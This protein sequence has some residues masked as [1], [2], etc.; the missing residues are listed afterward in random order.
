MSQILS[1]TWLNHY[2]A[3][4]SVN[5][6]SLNDEFD[7][8]GIDGIFLKYFLRST[9]ER[10]SADLLVPELFNRNNFK[11]ALIGGR[12]ENMLVLR[13]HFLEKFSSQSVVFQIDGFQGLMNRDWI[14]ELRKSEANFILIGLGAPLQDH[15]ATLIRKKFVNTRH[16]VVILTCGGF[17][18]QIQ[19]GVYYPRFSYALKMNWLVR[20]IREPKRLWKRYSIDAITFLISKE[21]IVKGIQLL[22]GYKKSESVKLN[23]DTLLDYTSL[24]LHKN[25]KSTDIQENR[26]RP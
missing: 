22:S 8:I 13:R 19:Q 25:I 10:T 21:K 3:L 11:V 9:Q 1:I 17:L 7:F 14:E 15:V 6:N 5:S 2:S 16:F 18:D 12:P 20:L 4:Q 26:K 24:M 23:I